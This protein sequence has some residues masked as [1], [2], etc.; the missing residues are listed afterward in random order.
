MDLPPSG[1]HPLTHVACIDVE[2]RIWSLPR[3]FRHHH[4]IK[5]MHDFG[6]KNRSIG[7]QGFLDQSGRYLTR[8]QA[9]VS[10]DVNG[11]IKNGKIIGGC[12]T[13]EDLW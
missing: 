1:R 10:A 13:S 3:P 6:A 4:I 7:D 12:L 8:N 5:I 11:Q 9:E 2:G